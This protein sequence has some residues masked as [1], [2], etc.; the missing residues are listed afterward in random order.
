MFS[1]SSGYQ[2]IGGDDINYMKKLLDYVTFS[3]LLKD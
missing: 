3:L 2:G 1:G